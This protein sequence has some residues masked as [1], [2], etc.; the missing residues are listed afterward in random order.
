MVMS[1]TTLAA[2]RENRLL[3]SPSDRESV[4]P[5]QTLLNRVLDSLP[6]SRATM[7]AAGN[8]LRLR[9]TVS[10]MMIRPRYT[11]GRMYSISV[12]LES[13]AA[14]LAETALVATW[15]CTPRA[16]DRMVSPM[17]RALAAGVC[18]SQ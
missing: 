12:A 16:A 3:M 18:S 15:I 4:L 6:S 14:K 9:P 11:A 5:A 13:F 17:V 8:R 7:N 2:S 1:V 10:P